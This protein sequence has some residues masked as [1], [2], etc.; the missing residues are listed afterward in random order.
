LQEGFFSTGHAD[1]RLLRQLGITRV[2]DITGLDSIGIPVWFATRPNSRALSVSQG[3]GSTDAQARISAVMEAAEGALAERPEDL[4]AC[5][6]TI[7]EMAA[8]H[9]LTV[10]LDRLMRCQPSRVRHDHPYAWVRGHALKSGAEI[11]APYELIGLD[12]RAATPWDHIAFKMS[13]IGLAAGGSDAAVI[14]HGLLEVIEHDATASLDLLGLAGGVAVPVRHEP[15]RHDDLDCLVGLV[16]AAGFMPHFFALTA[17]LPIPVVGCFFERQVASAEGVGA[18]LTAGFACRP[19]AYDAAVAA[20]LECVQSRATDIAGSRDDIKDASYAGSRATLPTGG[21]GALPDFG[22]IAGHASRND[23]ADAQA[24][25]EHV[26]GTV[27]GS[28]IEDIYCFPL[29]SPGLDIKVQ[30]ILVPGLGASSEGGLNQGSAGL[31]DALLKAV[32]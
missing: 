29:S 14:G 32:S 7:R 23:F 9:R 2:G 10:P 18:T 26:T 12:L 16:R 21:E 25:F 27:L 15:G 30:R 5:F 22:A 3:K 19:D 6:G 1:A 13:S 28:G 4:V 20:L 31:I 11:W 24:R 8:Q 17:R